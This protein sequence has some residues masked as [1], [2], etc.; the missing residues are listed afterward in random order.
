MNYGSLYVTNQLITNLMFYIEFQI[1]GGFFNLC[2]YCNKDAH[3]LVSTAQIKT[4]EGETNRYRFS[5]GWI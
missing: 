5:G 3:F 4:V 1:W 2:A